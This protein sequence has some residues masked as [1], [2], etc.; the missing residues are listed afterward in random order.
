MKANFRGIDHLGVVVQDL[1]AAA[2]TWGETLGFDLTGDEGGQW[3]M[4]IV[5]GACDVLPGPADEPTAVVT[6]EAGEF[7]GINT[8]EVS[9]VEVFWSG[10]IEVEGEIDAVIALQAIM[11]WR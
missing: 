4:F 10:R 3:T 7:V 6:M 2:A 8:G 9:A 11:D 5:A 1:E